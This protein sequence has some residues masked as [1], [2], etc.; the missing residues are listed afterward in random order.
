MEID[1][2]KKLKNVLYKSK[3]EIESLKYF[4]HKIKSNDKNVKFCQIVLNNLEKMLTFDI[5]DIKKD[6]DNII[7]KNENEKRFL[8]MSKI[9]SPD[10]DSI[11]RLGKFLNIN[12][13]IISS[14]LKNSS[15][16]NKREI[17]G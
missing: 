13:S 10:K 11:K 17:N 7:K 4:L 2:F 9:N 3:K 15:N 12:S 16:I 8:N 6:I 5:V 1:D 14:A